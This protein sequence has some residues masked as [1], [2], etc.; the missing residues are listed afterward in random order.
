MIE[1]GPLPQRNFVILQNSVVRDGA[2]SFKARGVLGFL[3]SQPAGYQTSADAIAAASHSDG[4]TAILSALRELEDAG[5][6]VRSTERLPNGTFV[7]HATVYDAPNRD[8][9]EAEN[10]LPVPPAETRKS[11]GRTGSGFPDAGKPADKSKELEPEELEEPNLLA[12]V[13]AEV[14]IDT[15]EDLFWPAWP[16]KRDKAAARKAWPR[17]VRSAGSADTI[18][19]A[20]RRFA[21][22]P[23]LPPAGS[24]YMP[25]ASS[26]LNKE[27][28]NDPPLPTRLD[29]RKAGRSGSSYDAIDRAAAMVENHLSTP[30]PK[31]LNP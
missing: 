5:Y 31:A 19:A 8:Q 3:L 15:F 14:P 1:R 10:L 16:D 27:R 25:H 17:A 30:T 20:A 22:D 29:A 26:W 9:P 13:V 11:P 21:A 4:R 24:Q 28:W 7:N 2:L 6:L 18:V 23:N 12:A